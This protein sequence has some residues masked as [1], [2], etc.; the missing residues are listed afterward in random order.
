MDE[1]NIEC[2]FLDQINGFKPKRLEYK[3][4]ERILQLILFDEEY[5]DRQRTLQQLK[6][7]FPEGLAILDQVTE[8]LESIFAE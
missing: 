4:E 7:K 1:G 3:L 2:E 8:C 5:F 6:V